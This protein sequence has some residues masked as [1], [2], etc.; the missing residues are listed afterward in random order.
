[1][2]NAI[3]SI[4]APMP[5]MRILRDR[6]CDVNQT[7]RPPVGSRVKIFLEGA[8]LSFVTLVWPEAASS[9]SIAAVVVGTGLRFGMVPHES[10]TCCATGALLSEV[11][12]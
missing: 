8:D 12:S 2:I 3:S 1:M 6:F 7:P 9:D 4:P 5:M 10:C 11:M